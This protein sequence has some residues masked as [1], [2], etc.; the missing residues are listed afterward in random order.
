MID[1]KHTRKTSKSG[2]IYSA[3]NMVSDAGDAYVTE[4]GTRFLADADIVGYARFDD[5]TVVVFQKPG[6][7]SYLRDGQLE[8]IVNDPTLDFGDY[9][10]AV[11]AKYQ[12][13]RIVYWCDY[14]NKDRF[15]NLDNLS[16]HFDD[17][18]NLDHVKIWIHA[19]AGHPEWQVAPSGYDINKEGRHFIYLELYDGSDTLLYRS[20]PKG[21]YDMIDGVA[22]WQVDANQIEGNAAYARIIDMYYSGEGQLHAVGWQAPVVNGQ[23]HYNADMDEAFS[24]DINSTLIDP[25]MF[26]ASAVL[27]GY[28][29]RLFRFGL[30]EHA[31]DFSK[32]Q[33]LASSACTKY[34]VQKVSKDVYRNGEP[35]PTLFRNGVYAVAVSFRLR[36]G[37]RTP[38]FHV[39]GPSPIDCGGEG[40]FLDNIPYT[41]YLTDETLPVHV[42]GNH[43][44]Q[45]D[46]HGFNNIY[47]V[48]IFPDIDIKR[49]VFRLNNQE[50]KLDQPGTLLL[51]MF[52]GIPDNAPDITLRI[53][54]TDLDVYEWTGN[55]TFDFDTMLLFRKV[56]YYI[57]EGDWVYS[58]C[59][60]PDEEPMEG[61][62]SSGRP[63]YWEGATVYANPP[64]YCGDDFWGS[65]CEGKPLL[66]TPMRLFRM[67]T[68]EDEPLE[69]GDFVRILGLHVDIDYG[70]HPDIIGYDLYVSQDQ[71]IMDK[72]FIQP[73]LFDTDE[74]ETF[75]NGPLL[76][77]YGAPLELTTQHM[78]ASTFVC[79]YGQAYG[80]T[81]VQ[82]EGEINDQVTQD[83]E[84]RKNLFSHD[85]PYSDLMLYRKA[86]KVNILGISQVLY[87]TKDPALLTP[88]GNKKDKYNLSYNSSIYTFDLDPVTLTRPYYGSLW[89]MNFPD[90]FS[91]DYFPTGDGKVLWGMAFIVPFNILNV[92]WV[93]IG[94]SYPGIMPGPIAVIDD[95]IGDSPVKVEYEVFDSFVE[96]LYNTYKFRYDDPDFRIIEFISEP[97]QDARK[98]KDRIEVLDRTKGYLFQPIPTRRRLFDWYAPFCGRCY[99]EQ[100]TLILASDPADMTRDGRRTFRAGAS[101]MLDERAGR[102]TGAGFFRDTLSVVCTNGMYVIKPQA[103]TLGTDAS[104]IVL[105]GSGILDLPPT[106]VS[107]SNISDKRCADRSDWIMTPN[108][109]VFLDYESKALWHYSEKGINKVSW[110][111]LHRFLKDFMAYRGDRK[112]RMG[113]DPRH[114]RVVISLQNRKSPKY[115]DVEDW[116]FGLSYDPKM[117]S[118]LSFHSWQADFLFC[119]NEGLYS[120]KDGKLYR[121]DGP[122]AFFYGEQHYSGLEQIIQLEGKQRVKNVAFVATFLDGGGN[123]IDPPDDV[124]IWVHT[125]HQH[126]GLRRID[127]RLYNLTYDANVISFRSHGIVHRVSMIRD[128]GNGNVTRDIGWAARSQ[129]PFWME[130]A[131]GPVTI[132]TS[133]VAVSEIKDTYIAFRVMVKGGVRFIVTSPFAVKTSS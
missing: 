126:T 108:G 12:C 51:D 81:H 96:S 100:P 123:A 101:M 34:V 17:D 102:I 128:Y 127:K 20:L 87:P 28:N 122:L 30:I 38:L 79:R 119:D 132:P 41:P 67:P 90:I 55:I 32:L 5:D 42:I 121:H 77:T 89:R 88:R 7:I 6:R 75:T 31:L 1:R 99:N 69:D 72:G 37:R 10:I 63:A 53:I 118:F 9:I 19:F 114:E 112:V 98:L 61:F 25:V 66:G 74:H 71:C 54:T 94:N 50:D 115:E 73:H 16:Q 11:A 49:I 15:L 106:E 60:I 43:D 86:H 130:E 29:G 109:F 76:R 3:I 40:T 39:P 35:P 133:P 8:E 62:E 36:D 26:D 24:V 97:Y 27:A 57:H 13:G 80:S 93:R 107:V 46:D 85:L 110:P 70:A 4:A 91:L 82:L 92:T 56:G 84:E 95:V 120:V 125:D 124:Y 78:F 64:N 33:H 23:V 48:S 129:L 14:K 116:S 68:I 59:A 104:T 111:S 65:D 117:M 83:D 45:P 103:Q 21:P 44:A 47:Q 22:T 58:N 131:P 105:K 52:S 18:G 2:T 113:Y